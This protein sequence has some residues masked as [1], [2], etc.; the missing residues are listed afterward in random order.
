MNITKA[1]ISA[2][3][4]AMAAL[5]GTAYAAIPNN[6]NEATS[7]T[8]T[9]ANLAGLSIGN[10]PAGI[11]TVVTNLT[12]YRTFE[13]NKNANLVT[14]NNAAISSV[15]SQQSSIDAKVAQINA[16]I[17]ANP[18]DAQIPVEQA[19]LAVQQANLV[20]LQGAQAAAAAAVTNSDTKITLYTQA[21]DNPVAAAKTAAANAAASITS[22]RQQF[23]AGANP[24]D[25]KYAA[26]GTAG[27]QSVVDVVANVAAGDQAPVTNAITAA[28]GVFAGIGA[29]NATLADIQTLVG[30]INTQL[31]VLPPISEA[32][33]NAALSSVLNGSYER[34]AILAN[35]TAITAEAT[36]R[37][38]LIRQELD[39]SLH[40]GA[41]SLIT[42]EVG[43]VQQLYA[44]DAL[45]N[46]IDISVTNGS[47]L[48]VNGF[49]VATDADVTAE[50]TTRATADTALQANITA[51]AATRAAADTVLQTNITAEAT[52]R[53]TAD[54]ALQTNITA[55]AAARVLGDNTLT[56]SINTESARAIAAESALD[57][58]TTALEGSV[59]NLY[60][61]LKVIRKGVAMAASLQT[62]VINQGDKSAVSVSAAGFDGEAGLSVGY[63]RRINSKTTV[64]ASV[65]TGFPDVLARG[66]LNYSF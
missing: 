63:A 35:T 10:L 16:L 45:S 25:Q 53:A 51:E 62:P 61:N 31:P 58:R 59:N 33:K 42:N 43:G 36:S 48:L 2:V 40:I 26:T 4:V 46:P 60:Q 11:Q 55:E 1:Q 14:A 44:Q 8:Q 41:N 39:G 29:N 64:N 49:S 17:L 22:A 5:T 32:D 15:N 3:L 24:S 27:L 37:T 34:A 7:F 66:G 56:T 65:A 9:Q 18:L 6:T 52:T 13:Q 23:A 30:V 38:S 47:D 28:D 57:T 21:I 19:N 50:A 12:G 54:T 20:T